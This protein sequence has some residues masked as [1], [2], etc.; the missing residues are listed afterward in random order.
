MHFT[1]LIDTLPEI[2]RSADSVISVSPLYIDYFRDRVGDP[3]P[4]K[5]SI[6][7]PLSATVCR[8]WIVDIV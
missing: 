7:A 1:T 8:M 5:T 3:L 4:P 6:V 2:R